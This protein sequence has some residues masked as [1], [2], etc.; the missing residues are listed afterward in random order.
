VTIWQK[1]L[2]ADSDWLYW[3]DIDGKTPLTVTIS[4]YGSWEAFDTSTK[5]Q[6]QLF[7]LEF[8]GGKKR[9]GLC[10][11]QAALIEQHHGPDHAEWIGKKIVLRVAEC[12]GERC[13]R[14]DAKQG[15]K[16]AAKYPRFRYLDGGGA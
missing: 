5:K 12:K 6:K 7:G 14:V 10:K 1:D 8:K 3:W 4:N 13:I 16:L 15:A 11:T 9:L 2:Y